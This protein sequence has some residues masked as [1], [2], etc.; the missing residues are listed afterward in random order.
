MKRTFMLSIICTLAMQCNTS[1]KVGDGSASED[2]TSS[3]QILSGSISDNAL[4]QLVRE[5]IQAMEDEDLDKAMSIMSENMK[6][7]E[8]NRI[9]TQQMFDVYDLDYEIEKINVIEQAE[10]KAQIELAYTIKKINGAEFYDQ[11]NRVLLHFIKENNEWKVI[12]R[13][14]KNIEYL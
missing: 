4:I 7:V 3:E 2:N 6:G 14:I 9:F 5:N 1:G 12:R 11:R 8:G 10:N 13:D